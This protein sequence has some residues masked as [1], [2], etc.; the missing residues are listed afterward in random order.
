MTKKLLPYLQQWKDASWKEKVFFLTS[1]FMAWGFLHFDISRIRFAKWGIPLSL[2]EFLGGVTQTKTYLYITEIYILFLFILCFSQPKQSIEKLC[3]AIRKKNPLFLLILTLFAITILRAIPDFSLNPLLA[4]RNASFSWYMIIPILVYLLQ[5]RSNLLEHL[6]LLIQ[7]IA[8][9]YF[10]VH[11]LLDFNNRPLEI[12]W[13][14]FVG[15]AAPFAVALLS[16]NLRKSILIFTPISFALAISFWQYFQRTTLIGLFITIFFILYYHKEKLPFL[17]KK[18]ALF[19]LLLILSIGGILFDTS[20]TNPFAKSVNPFTKSVNPFIK[21]EIDR[22][23]LEK[24]RKQMWLDALELYIENPLTGI[25]FQKQVVYRLYQGGGKYIPNDG[26]G[27]ENKVSAPISGPHNSYLNAMVRIGCLGIFL[28]ILH[29]L[30]LQT[31]WFS[32][33]WAAFFLLFSGILYAG[34]NIGLEGPTR[35]FFLLLT[36]GLALKRYQE[37]HD[38]R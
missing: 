36:L 30:A 24:F 18:L 5:L 34:F 14:P 28:F 4:I 17:V 16:K 3:D 12:Y 11:L 7:I 15:I 38:A 27:W 22:S 37:I 10:S 2:P 33:D 20:F 9:F 23:G 25:G 1:L 19:M 21:S 35:S 32:K 29:L 6:S 26:M 13:I 8:F 31:L